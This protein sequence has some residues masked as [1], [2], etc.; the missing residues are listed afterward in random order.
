[1]IVSPSRLPTPRPPA[2]KPDTTPRNTPPT[3]AISEEVS[4]IVRSMRGA[5]STRERMSIPDTSVPIGWCSDGGDSPSPASARSGG[6]GATYGPNTARKIVTATIARPIRKPVRFR[7][8]RTK[9]A[10]PSA[11]SVG[12]VVVAVPV[13]AC[14]LSP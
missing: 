10:N 14:M 13:S 8:K 9:D 11:L 12:S 6:Y 7:A 3:K 1:M 4:A 5:A 2:K